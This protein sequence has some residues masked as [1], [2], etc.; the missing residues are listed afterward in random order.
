MTLS[1]TLLEAVLDAFERRIMGHRS[2]QHMTFSVDRIAAHARTTS[3]AVVSAMR[4]RGWQRVR[5]G[6][7]GGE[8]WIVRR[9]A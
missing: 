6:H 1:Q 3:R 2:T 8:T 9:T 5:T 4:A 7:C